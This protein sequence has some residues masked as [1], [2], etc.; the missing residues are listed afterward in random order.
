VSVLSFFEHIRS[1]LFKRTTELKHEKYLLDVFGDADQMPKVLEEE[2]EKA[3]QQFAHFKKKSLNELIAED[4]GGKIPLSTLIE[5]YRTPKDRIAVLEHQQNITLG[6]DSVAPQDRFKLTKMGL[7]KKEFVQRWKEVPPLTIQ[8]QDEQGQ[9]KDYLIIAE[10][11]FDR[12]AGKDVVGF[13][14]RDITKALR[15][16]SRYL[17]TL[18]QADR[19]YNRKEKNDSAIKEGDHKAYAARYGVNENGL[20][21]YLKDY[22]TE[23][24]LMI[25]MQTPCIVRTQDFKGEPEPSRGAKLPG[26]KKN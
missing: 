17:I 15:A 24:M 12:R 22:I 13:Y 10:I 23:D 18:T 1:G 4:N 7:S 11:H 16:D 20:G 3:E 2:I 21:N 9:V 19:T 14:K 8:L 26:L 6:D 25:K 5:Q